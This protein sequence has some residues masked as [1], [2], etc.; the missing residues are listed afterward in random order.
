MD[1]HPL[2]P[3]ITT[4]CV[5]DPIVP[6]TNAFLHCNRPWT[7]I[8]LKYLSAIQAADLRRRKLSTSDDAPPV[9][10]FVARCVIPMKSPEVAQ[11]TPLILD[12]DRIENLKIDT[13]T[14]G[15]I[16]YVRGAVVGFCEVSERPYG[17]GDVPG[18]TR[19]KRK[20]TN[21]P[22]NPRRPFLT[23]LSVAREARNSGIGSQ[24]M[25]ACE[26]AVE[27]WGGEEVIL[28]VEADNDRALEFYQKRGY[29]K[30]FSDPT[31]RRFTTA[32]FLL[33][34]ERCIKVCMRKPL[35]GS[36]TAPKKVAIAMSTKTAMGD[37][38]KLFQ[39]FRESVFS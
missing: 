35:D 25:E 10:M 11:T 2:F 6:H 30:V 38:S 32:G 39:S 17:L 14:S 26:A 8:Q 18:A 27:S 7:L 36:T 21:G 5:V 22:A 23:N 19:G 12:L 31:G 37:L 9:A 28:E 29:N 24:L 16:D 4:P 33:S 13:T 1:L 3:F 34:K 15:T 20:T